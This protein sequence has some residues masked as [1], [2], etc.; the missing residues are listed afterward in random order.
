MQ[1]REKREDVG[2]Q[3]HDVGALVKALIVLATLGSAE[4][5][6]ESHLVV[7]GSGLDLL[8]FLITVPTGRRS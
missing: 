3:N 4:V 5:V 1:S 2:L 7:T 8:Q 6:L